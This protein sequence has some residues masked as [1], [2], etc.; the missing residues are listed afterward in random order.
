MTFTFELPTLT[1][2]RSQT[3]LFW[4]EK[5]AAEPPEITGSPSHSR[6]ATAPA[7][8]SWLLAA[9]ASEA[10]RSVSTV[11]GALSTSSFESFKPS[12][13]TALR[14]LMTFTFELPTLTRFRSQTSPV[15]REAPLPTCV[16]LAWPDGSHDTMP[17]TINAHMTHRRKWF[18]HCPLGVSLRVRHPPRRMSELSATGSLRL[19]CGATTQREYPDAYYGVQPG[20]GLQDPSLRRPVP[21]GVRLGGAERALPVGS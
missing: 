16:A 19:S 6:A 8:S 20:S 13:V 4:S 1:R 15:P 5:S 17:P 18:V 11:E 10:G 21:G 14:A 7:P 3:S 2:F 12:P 9:S